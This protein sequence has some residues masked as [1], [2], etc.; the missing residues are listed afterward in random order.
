MHPNEYEEFVSKNE[1]Y[2][3]EEDPKNA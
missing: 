3:I 1:K 2:I